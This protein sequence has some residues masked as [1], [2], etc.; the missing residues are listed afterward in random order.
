MECGEDKIIGPK[1][2]VEG[3][4]H[5]KKMINKHLQVKRK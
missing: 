2:K 4:A 3:F 1:G 5:P